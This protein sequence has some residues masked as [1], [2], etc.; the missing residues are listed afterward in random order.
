VKFGR[1]AKIA[2][3]Q[4][5]H[6]EEVGILRKDFAID[7]MGIQ[8]SLLVAMEANQEILTPAALA[9]YLKKFKLQDTDEVDFISWVP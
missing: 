8:Q 1:V 4:N 7:K 2:K 3:W 9:E 5:K 6:Y